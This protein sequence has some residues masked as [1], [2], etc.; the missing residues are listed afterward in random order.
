[1]IHWSSDTLLQVYV[2]WHRVGGCYRIYDMVI[3]LGYMNQRW[4]TWFSIYYI[5]ELGTKYEGYPISGDGVLQWNIVDH[6]HARS[7]HWKNWGEL[8][9]LTMDEPEMITSTLHLWTVWTL[10]LDFGI[11]ATWPID[12]AS[13]RN[14]FHHKKPHRVHIP[15]SYTRHYHTNKYRLFQ[16]SCI[17]QGNYFLQT[18]KHAHDAHFSCGSR[19]IARLHKMDCSRFC[20]WCR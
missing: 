1:M 5:H 16:V 15:I 2:Y 18:W 14:C 20:Y 9:Q 6:C 3:Q 7:K 10:H 4:P 19:T 11:E 17:I 12:D 13:I 8:T